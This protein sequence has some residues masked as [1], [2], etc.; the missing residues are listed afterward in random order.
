MHGVIV[1]QAHPTS[2]L[3]LTQGR[4]EK[5]PQERALWGEQQ[6]LG[7][8]APHLRGDEGG[9]PGGVAGSRERASRGHCRHTDTAPGTAGKGTGTGAAGAARP[10]GL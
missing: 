9:I 10:G 6:A 2:S 5:L 3:G 4:L 1:V 8:S 7:G